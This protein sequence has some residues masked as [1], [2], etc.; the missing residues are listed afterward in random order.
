MTEGKPS[1]SRQTWRWVEF[2]IFFFLNVCLIYRK[3]HE[4]LAGIKDGEKGV[5]AG[6]RARLGRERCGDWCGEGCR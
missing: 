6:K 5:M 4:E 3:R 1:S 2:W